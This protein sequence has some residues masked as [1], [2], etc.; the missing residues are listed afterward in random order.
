M[1][2]HKCELCGKVFDQKCNY[3]R[4][5][6][7]KVKCDIQVSN[8]ENKCSYCGKRFCDT[9]ALHKHIRNNICDHKKK[10]LI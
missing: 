9:S 5:I 2:E 6:N 4:H 8:P 7:R 1:V 10:T 3:D